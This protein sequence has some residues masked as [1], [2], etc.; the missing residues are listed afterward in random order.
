M[1]L[2][3]INAKIENI[4]SIQ[5]AKELDKLENKIV[6]LSPCHTNSSPSRARWTKKDIEIPDIGS[7]CVQ[8]IN[9]LL[10]RTSVFC[11][12]NTACTLP[13]IEICLLN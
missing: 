11:G 5:L 4:E 9:V 3:E 7:H 1:K 12:L 10:Q 6:T 2:I 13:S 8:H